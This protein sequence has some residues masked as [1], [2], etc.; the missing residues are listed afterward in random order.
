MVAR[1]TGSL[2]DVAGHSF[3]TGKNLGAFGDAGA[4]TTNDDKLA[5]VLRALSNYGSQKKYVSK[6]QGLN[7]RLD[8]IQ[9]A[10]LN[11][12]LS[13]LVEDN[14]L[15]KKMAKYYID[16]ITNPEIILPVVN[17]WD[18]HVFHV[19]TIR[20][21]QRD[22]LQKYLY[23]NGV[24]TLIHYPIPPHKQACYAEWNSLTFPVTELIHAQ[25]LS[26]PIS[27]VICMDDVNKVTQLINSFK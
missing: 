6:Y 13:H 1:K 22:K 15:C 20:T 8:E 5:H 23:D 14:L 21:S 7:S 2:G 27:P 19:F 18:A 9:T 10:F 17:D 26:L 25:E 3:Y 4:V 16:N 24:Q 11:V 12:K